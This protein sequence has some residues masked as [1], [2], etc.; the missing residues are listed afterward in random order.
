MSSSTF[1]VER[2][3]EIIVEATSGDVEI[4][5]HDESTVRVSGSE[6]RYQLQQEEGTLRVKPTRSGSHD[7]TLQVPH[8]CTLS[9]RTASGD[10][11][12]QGIDGTCSVKAASGDISAREL[13]GSL[14]V[15]TASGDLHVGDSSL[16][17]VLIETASG[18]SVLETTLDDEGKYVYHSVSGDL[19][20]L[21]PEDQACTIVSTSLS[22]HVRCDLPHES[23]REARGKTKVHV[24]GGGVEWRISTISG[25]VRVKAAGDVPD[26]GAMD[27]DLKPF[28]TAREEA[29]AEAEPFSLNAEPQDASQDSPATAERR[30]EILKAIESGVLS[31]G[32]GLAK[33]RAL[34]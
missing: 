19:S 27:E 11:D 29:Q 28:A 34:D 2:A 24:N 3:T 1:A 31:V 22:G 16:R 4:R 32:D 15:H 25:D 17:E 7:L 14:R 12:L 9:V 18:D 10:V 13:S 20:L 6:D 33:L 21:V 23:E 5:G 26:D 30:M 8:E